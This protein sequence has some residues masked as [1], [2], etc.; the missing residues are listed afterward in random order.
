MSNPTINVT[1]SSLAKG[2]EPSVTGTLDVLEGSQVDVSVMWP[3]NATNTIQCDLDFSESDQDPFNDKTGGESSFEMTRASSNEAAVQTLTVE[4]D[5][6]FKSDSYD[7]KLT[8]DGVIYTKDPMIIVSGK[9]P[10]S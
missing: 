4:N 5:A 10:L 8:I 3:S 6:K 9:P 7:L 1:L 2:T